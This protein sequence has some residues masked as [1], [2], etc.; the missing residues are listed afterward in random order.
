MIELIPKSPLHGHEPLDIGGVHFFEINAGAMTSLL[1]Y[2]GKANA[3]SKA[4]QKCHDVSLPE[5]NRTTGKTGARVIWF[6]REHTLLMGP[7]PNTS[8]AKH[9]AL[10]DQTDSWTVAELRGEKAEAVLSRLCPLDLRSAVFKRGHTGRTELSHMMASVTRIGVQSFQIMVFR[11]M[12]K[13]LTHD[14]R[15]AMESVAAR[16]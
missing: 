7:E 3:L 2:K 5:P 15:V 13:T 8:L 12:A 9:A 14:M 6:G 16:K 1:P 11:S 4:L 10:V